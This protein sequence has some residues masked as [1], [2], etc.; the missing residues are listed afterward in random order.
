MA[1]LP[2]PD[3]PHA[4][5]IRGI[6]PSTGFDTML[7]RSGKQKIT[8][9]IGIGPGK[10]S[11]LMGIHYS[12]S[13]LDLMT[14]PANRSVPAIWLEDSGFSV[15]SDWITSGPRIGVD[16]AGDDALLPYRF[17]IPVHYLQ[18]DVTEINI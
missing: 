18:F 15:N 17:S 13:G 11:T 4:V 2:L 8:K 6:M 14:M 10:V 12:H 9:E 7:L 1:L 3:V 16:Y 5:L